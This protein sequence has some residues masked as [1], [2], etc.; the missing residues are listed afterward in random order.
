MGNLWIIK[1]YGSKALLMIVGD[2]IYILYTSIH[3]VYWGL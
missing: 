3:K 2:Y 1:K